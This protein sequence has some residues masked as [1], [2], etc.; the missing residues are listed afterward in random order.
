MCVCV[1]VCHQ[2]EPIQSRWSMNE[3][4]KCDTMKDRKRKILD[5]ISIIIDRIYITFSN[6]NEIFFYRY[7]SPFYLVLSA[8]AHASYLHIIHFGFVKIWRLHFFDAYFFCILY[9]FFLFWVNKQSTLSPQPTAF[10]L[11]NS[12]MY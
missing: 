7:C 8:C 3:I 10:V 1:C 2:P 6:R 4:P 5:E 12:C 11:L 9:Y